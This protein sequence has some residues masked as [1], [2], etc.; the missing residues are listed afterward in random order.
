MSVRHAHS[1]RANASVQ[2][3]N[4]KEQAAFEQEL[5]E[6]S[7]LIEQVAPAGS[8]THVVYRAFAPAYACM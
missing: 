8:R 4:D 3:Q 1:P 5:R 6:L 2:A 7:R